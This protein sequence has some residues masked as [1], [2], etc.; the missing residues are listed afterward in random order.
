MVEDPHD[1]R[2]RAFVVILLLVGGGAVASGL[3]QLVVLSITND[4]AAV[5]DVV[6][7]FAVLL[8]TW[9][10]LAPYVFP[11]AL[12]VPKPGD[13]PITRDY[14]PFPIAPIPD[15]GVSPGASARLSASSAAA[16]TPSFYEQ[17]GGT[18]TESPF[19]SSVAP[20][21][22]NTR[23]RPAD[24]G[25]ARLPEIPPLHPAS[26]TPPPADY[27]EGTDDLISPGSDKEVQVTLSELGNLANGLHLPANG[28]GGSSKPEE[29]LATL[30][31][32]ETRMTSPS[33]Q[34]GIPTPPPSSKPTPSLPT[35]QLASNP[36]PTVVA[37]PTPVPVPRGLE[38]R[39]VP[40]TPTA[41]PL[42]LD[43]LSRELE[44][45]RAALMANLP[46]PASVG[47]EPAPQP[48]AKTT[49]PTVTR[50]PPQATSDSA[51]ELEAA[52]QEARDAVLPP[53][54][55]TSSESDDPRNRP[56]PPQTP[57]TSAP[58]REAEPESPADD[59]Q[60]DLDELQRA[61]EEGESSARETLQRH[62]SPPPMKK[63]KRGDASTISTS[64]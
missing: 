39:P 62:S 42:D 21:R 23:R 7:G 27:L 2:D 6:L 64:P 59:L 38:P 28:N 49:V 29:V 58:Q 41:H 13:L 61:I 50:D 51:L 8:I 32:I 47:A 57:R 63:G 60:E 36:Q 5:F 35:V 33:R 30:D 34:S 19:S 48:A 15:V 43:S 1:L 24:P 22:R 54:G 20:S 52:I 11:H 10:F 44:G 26:E 45:V 18:A 37:P 56:T 53:R 46:S 12:G 9:L 4:P 16:S 14:L 55:V 31:Q 40:A 17:E 25:L 3:F